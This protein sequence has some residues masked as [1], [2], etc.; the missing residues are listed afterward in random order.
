MAWV[1][2]ES[3]MRWMGG[4]VV[5]G[6]VVAVGWTGVGDAFGWEMR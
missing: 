6:G 4:A 3:A 2:R 5:N 1:G